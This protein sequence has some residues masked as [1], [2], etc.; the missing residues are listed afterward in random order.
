[1]FA[2]G[3]ADVSFKIVL[4]WAAVLSPLFLVGVRFGVVGVAAAWAIGFP[5]VY[6]L[7]AR[8]VAKSLSIPQASLWTPMLA[9]AISA[10]GC[11]GVVL[12][13]HT[14]LAGELRPSAIL[15]LEVVG[16]A[17]TYGFLLRVLSR[18]A[19]DEILDLLRRL[20]GRGQP[21]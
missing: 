21:A 7:G 14:L 4:V 2:L 17:I 6:L 12:I 1:L 13:V 19:F 20:A 5:F 9:P 8:L 3:R 11:V 18:S 16:G 15:T 10:A